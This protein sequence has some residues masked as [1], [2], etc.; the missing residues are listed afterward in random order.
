MSCAHSL[1]IL[2]PNSN[3]NEDIVLEMQG[4]FVFYNGTLFSNGRN[5]DLRMEGGFS[6]DGGNI[7]CNDGDR[8]NIS[9]F[10]NGCYNFHV[11]CIGNTSCI[12]HNCD[13]S[14]NNGYQYGTACP[15]VY[16][17]N[18]T[19]GSINNNNNNNNNN[20]K[21]IEDSDVLDEIVLND[22]YGNTEE[23][24]KFIMWSFVPESYSFCLNIIE[25]GSSGR[26][27]DEFYRLSSVQCDDCGAY[28]GFSLGI[29]KNCAIVWQLVV[30]T[31]KMVM[32]FVMDLKVVK[33]I[34]TLHL[35]IYMLVVQK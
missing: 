10:D 23:L 8:C 15:N 9:C 32:L 14:V 29:T 30:K 24:A 7:Y 35:E 4:E 13:S 1:I 34:Q 16:Y 33:D 3:T 12:S 19:S 11:Y 26:L 6:A 20:N 27:N 31:V 2:K 5:M 21:E 18:T 17:T 28:S 22:Y 25:D